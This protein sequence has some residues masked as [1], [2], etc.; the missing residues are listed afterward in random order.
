MVGS[1]GAESNAQYNVRVYRAYLPGENSAHLQGIVDE[2][3]ES[4]KTLKE[5][6][7]IKR[8]GLTIVENVLGNMDAYYAKAAVA[9][10]IL[11][12]RNNCANTS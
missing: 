10:E 5:L 11:N 8:I 7:L 1:I 4:R 12:R 2:F 3:Y 9:E 6:P